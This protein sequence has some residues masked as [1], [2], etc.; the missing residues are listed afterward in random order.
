MLFVGLTSPGRA[1]TAGNA[2]PE[3]Q[4]FDHESAFSF[5]KLTRT[6][7]LYGFVGWYGPFGCLSWV[8]ARL[9]FRNPA[10][11][12][13]SFYRSWGRLSSSL[14]NLSPSSVRLPRYDAHS[15]PF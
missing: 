6:Q 7:R 10:C 11:V 4:L 5:L 1:E 9:M 14:A 8:A 12:S 3:N 13:D 15:I 2:M